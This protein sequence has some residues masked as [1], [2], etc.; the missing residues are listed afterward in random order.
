M[1]GNHYSMPLQRDSFASEQIYKNP[2][3]S[4]HTLLDW[5]NLDQEPNIL[6]LEILAALDSLKTKKAL[7]P[8]HG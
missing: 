3:T 7:G 8:D 4:N 6:R 1:M 5:S 2:T